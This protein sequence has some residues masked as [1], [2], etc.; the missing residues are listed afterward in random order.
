MMA[1]TTNTKKADVVPTQSQL[2]T[3]KK[4]VEASAGAE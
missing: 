2:A 4:A 1:R 3:T